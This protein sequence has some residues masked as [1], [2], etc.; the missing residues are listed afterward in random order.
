MTK[1]FKFNI[2]YLLIL[3]AAYYIYVNL[4]YYNYDLFPEVTSLDRISDMIKE[5]MYSFEKVIINEDYA[6]SYFVTN[7]TTHQELPNYKISISQYSDFGKDIKD[8][9]GSKNNLPIEIIYKKRIS[10]I[11]TFFHFVLNTFFAYRI[12]ILI[13]NLIINYFGKE[14]EQEIKEIQEHS[15]P[16]DQG[17]FEKLIMGDD[18]SFKII[19]DVSLRFND[20]IG[21]KYAKEDL[22]ECINFFEKRT[23]YLN[24]GYKI[25]RGLIFTGPPGTGKTLLAKSFAGEAGVTFISCSG[26][27]FLNMYVGG[28]S[29]KVRS[30]FKYAREHSPS[31]LFI[32]EVDAIGKKR[33]GK[34][35]GGGE[36]GQTLN[37]LLVEMDGFNEND[38]IIIIAA[39][40][41]A[42]VLDP[43]LTRSGRFDK[44]IIFDNPNK[45]ER[46]DL[47]KLY[48][49]KVKVHPDLID[50]SEI[51]NGIAKGICKLDFT[52]LA[53]MTAGLSC[54]DIS[55]ICNQSV[56]NFIKKN[57]IGSFNFEN[58]GITYKDLEEAIDIVAI[59]M[60]KPERKMSEKE[61]EIVAY[62]EAGHALVGY[63]LKQTDPPVK[64][65]IIPR[66]ESA[67]GFTQPEPSDQKIYTKKE[68]FARICVLFGGI[69]AE[70]I[71]FNHHSTGGND[72]LDKLTKISVNMVTRYSMINS[73]DKYKITGL[74]TYKE[75]S[76]YDLLS[77]EHKE[78]ICKNIINVV[79]SAREIVFTILEKHT[80]Y[81]K[82]LANKLKEEEVIV[83]E[84][85]DKLLNE[86]DIEN[87][88]DV[89]ED[90]NKFVKDYIED[91]INF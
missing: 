91:Y 24:A 88:I 20:V 79:E 89:K 22:K 57:P 47:F 77:N 83:K 10:G 90:I 42:D 18:D 11:S 17:V 74:N 31:V 37:T 76:I 33:T 8:I 2:N 66:G 7:E 78:Y 84:D 3:Y 14:E 49:K 35:L 51:N 53:K 87:S 81:L 25:P 80:E 58:N 71:I 75:S 16:M 32:D 38:N 9:Y 56:A 60:E 43:A 70:K 15:V 82:I 4:E 52:E 28:G 50:H 12:G 46:V 5:N 6:S 29:K 59:G 1:V 63:L 44:K 65:S 48:T 34:T 26:S 73:S 86:F 21:Q 27:D 45:D 39:T 64:V 40:N 85:I 62:H 30:V 23:D 68:L 54:A 13:L 61:I 69:C 67:L 72:D 19:R 36:N 41:R 55:N